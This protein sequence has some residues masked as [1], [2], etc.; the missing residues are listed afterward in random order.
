[1]MGHCPDFQGRSLRKYFFPYLGDHPEKTCE[2]KHYPPV[3][4]EGRAN[5]F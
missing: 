3:N 4:V 1:M 2:V 5:Y